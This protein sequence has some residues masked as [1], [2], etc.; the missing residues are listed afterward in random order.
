VHSHIPTLMLGDRLSF[1]QVLR[2]RQ[3]YKRLDSE[4]G[5]MAQKVRYRSVDSGFTA[6][7]M[8]D[9]DGLVIDYPPHWK[10]HDGAHRN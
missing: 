5:G 8:L 3:E 9:S 2:A 7:L 1:L 6:D 10:R 4:A